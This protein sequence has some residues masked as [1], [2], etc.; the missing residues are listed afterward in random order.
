MDL[1]ERVSALTTPAM[2]PSAEADRR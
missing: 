2:G 1:R